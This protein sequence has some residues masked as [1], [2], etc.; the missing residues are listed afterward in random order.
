MFETPCYSIKP[1]F[2]LDT[3]TAIMLVIFGCGLRENAVCQAGLSEDLESEPF[4]VDELE[5]CPYGQ[6]LTL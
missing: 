2:R 4:Y 1:I 6:R 5:I 3:H